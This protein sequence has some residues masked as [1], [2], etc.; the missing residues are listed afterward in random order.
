MSYRLRIS[1]RLR[2]RVAVL[3]FGGATGILALTG[4][5]GLA[6][7]TPTVVASA[8]TGPGVPWSPHGGIP[9]C[10]LYTPGC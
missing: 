9:R 8:S 3:I 1:S 7:S 5:V 6:S 2:R 4:P 10:P